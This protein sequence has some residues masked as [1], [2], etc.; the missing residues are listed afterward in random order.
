MAA[1]VR[2]MPSQIPDD[3]R[4]SAVLSLLFPKDGKLH[5]L[6]IRRFADGRAHS[7][8]IGFPG[9]KYEKTDADMKGTALREANEE[10]G[11]IS[12]DI[13]ILGALTPLYIPVS[14]F[15]VYPFVAY[16]G[17]QLE[18]N[19]S[20]EEVDEIFEIPVTYLM[21]QDNKIT[22]DVTS[23]AIPNLVLKNVNAYKMP[24]GSILWG[25]TAM[26]I[27]ELET[28]LEEYNV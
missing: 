12:S 26:M 2:P 7:G 20:A 3:A 16:S 28:I 18:Y 11:I 15:N 8:Q 23:P 19:I 10:V 21:Q 13:E 17:K 22:T 4:P 24:D 1:R 14:N 25:A 9:G 6:L 5:L 27:A